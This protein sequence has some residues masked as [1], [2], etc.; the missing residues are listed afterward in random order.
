MIKKFNEYSKNDLLGQ[1]DIEYVKNLKSKLENLE[2][3]IID[4]SKKL[5]QQLFFIGQG[6][7]SIDANLVDYSDH[8]LVKYHND[9]CKNYN[10]LS[11]HL[12]LCLIVINSNLDYQTLEVMLE[13]KA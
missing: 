10:K 4:V 1:C 5:P 7:I 8:L 2:K 13:L 12:A 11:K 6:E 3:E 9:L